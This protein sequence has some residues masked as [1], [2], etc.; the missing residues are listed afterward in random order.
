ML[1]PYVV[2]AAA[3]T[4]F[5]VPAMGAQLAMAAEPSTPLH[6]TAVK[7]N[8]TPSPSPS[9]DDDMAGMDHDGMPEEAHDDSS[10]ANEDMPGM[11]HDQPADMNDKDM[12]GMD[13]EASDMNDEDMPGM[14]HGETS[15]SHEE[16]SGGSSATPAEE[17]EEE[18]HG[19]HGEETVT[20]PRP[21]AAMVGA[22]AAVNGGVMISAA[23]LRRRDKRRAKSSPKPARPA[24]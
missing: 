18:G 3:L 7:P 20:E 19:T 22:F 17:Q 15:G 21:V 1:K 6:A 5:V 2:V 13:H 11:D 10:G 16:A 23:V 24:K 12:P 8:V 9:H 14:N 4:A